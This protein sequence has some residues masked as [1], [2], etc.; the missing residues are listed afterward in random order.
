[1]PE[2]PRV[3]ILRTAGTNCDYETQFAFERNGAY[4]ERIHI[5]R[6]L[7]RE[8]SLDDWRALVIP[9]GFSYG[10]D[11]SAG[12][13]L[14]NQLK[15]HFRDDIDRFLDEGKLILGICNGFQVLVKAGLLPGITRWKQEATLTWNDSAR[16][17][18]RWTYL[19]PGDTNC[20]FVEK[21]RR[22]Y[23]PVAHGEGKF[24]PASEEI[25]ADLFANA[26]VAFQYANAEGE[27]AGYPWNPNGSVEN[28]AGISDP[29]GCILGLMPHPERHVLPTHHPRWTREGLAPDPD[30]NSIFRN[31]VRYMC[32]RFGLQPSTKN[33]AAKAG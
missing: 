20:V 29:T 18:D 23:L 30:G 12:R 19:V 17:E 33:T 14:A 27:L 2:Q 16:F 10:D 1:M 6:L 28:I 22:I 8:V 25:L 24:I 7:R 13:I 21:G 15:H 5:N 4:A 26:Q 11:I 9:G 3:L 31:A 32:E